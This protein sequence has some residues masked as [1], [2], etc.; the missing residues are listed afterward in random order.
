VAD[1]VNVVSVAVMVWLASRSQA[2]STPD[3]S[4]WLL[5]HLGHLVEGTL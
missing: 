4:A 3:G 5:L 2:E 1:I